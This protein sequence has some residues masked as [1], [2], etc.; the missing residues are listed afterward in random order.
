[1][2]AASAQRT[3]R[4]KV[5]LD[6]S[7]VADLS[8][9][10]G[11]NRSKKHRA[12]ILLA[13]NEKSQIAIAKELKIARSTLQEWMANEDFAAV[14]KMYEDEIIADALRLPIAKQTERVAVLND[15][16]QTYR[17]IQQQRGE[18]YGAA[19]LTPEEAARSIFG[20]DTPPW[21]ASGM[22][23][24]QPKIAASGKTVTEWAFDKALDSA[25]KDTLK[26]AAQ[27]LGQWAEKREVSGPGGESLTII[28]TEREDGPQ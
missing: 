4:G 11:P 19:A 5:T 26:H 20:T 3:S 7:A 25:I 18:T 14:Q 9:F 17:Q 6:D 12:A 2:P 15:L 13:E 27:E 10:A 21:A 28:L 16:L 24:A 1:M 8:F 23:V 22:F